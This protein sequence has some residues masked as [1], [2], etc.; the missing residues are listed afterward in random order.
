MNRLDYFNLKISREW[1]SC[2][3]VIGKPVVNYKI[4]GYLITKLIDPENQLGCGAASD[5]ISLS[6]TFTFRIAISARFRKMF[7]S[8]LNRFQTRSRLLVIQ[9]SSSSSCDS[10]M[11]S[12][13]CGPFSQP[14][15][16]SLTGPL[17][18]PRIAI[19]SQWLSSGDNQL[20]NN[21]TVTEFQLPD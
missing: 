1:K 9:V 12:K 13:W 18:M 2:M 21:K 5:G 8:C 3:R 19:L 14:A 10:V 16:Q 4:W 11:L 20:T 15:L 17:G 7:A 6:P